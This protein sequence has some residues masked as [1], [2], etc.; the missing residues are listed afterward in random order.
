MGWGTDFASANEQVSQNHKILVVSQKAL[1]RT[2]DIDIVMK[3][4]Q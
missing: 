4:M 2:C 1:C 3:R